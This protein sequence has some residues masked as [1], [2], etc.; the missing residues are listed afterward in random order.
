MTEPIVRAHALAKH[1]GALAAVAGIDFEIEPGIC[2]GFLGP[3]G[4]GKTTTLR[5]CMGL[6]PPDGGRLEIFGLSLPRH[7]RRVRARMGVVPQADNLD[8]DFTVEENLRIYGRYFG[9]R[10]RILD[11]RIPALLEFAALAERAHARTEALSGGMKRRLTLARALIN[12]PQLVVLDE[13][14]TG[15]D[16]Q[17]RHL[18]WARLEQLRARG[19]TLLLTTHYMEEAERLCDRLVVMDHGS[20]LDTGTPRE[21]VNRHV[22]PEVV[23]IRNAPAHLEGHLLD[24]G[25]RIERV[26]SS[27]YCYTRRATALIE[28]LRDQPGLV[29]LHRPAG[30]ED[31]FLRLTGRELRD[32]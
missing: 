24:G 2:F 26:G 9:L 4:A 19:T 8:P 28:H 10:R 6:S 17:A 25:C 13:P 11:T 21:L 30:L 16:P 7:G 23:E 20:I 32:T 18:V 15:L 3:N 14:T 31:V 29:F 27:L 5:M 22:E 12:D 1:Y